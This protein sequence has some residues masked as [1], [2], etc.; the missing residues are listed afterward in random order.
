MSKGLELSVNAIVIIL[1]TVMALVIIGMFVMG[2]ITKQ[3]D[4]TNMN[5]IF[6]DKCAAYKSAGCDWSLTKGSDFPSFLKACKYLYGNEYEA[7]SC[8][9]KFCCGT[10]KSVECDGLCSICDANKLAGIETESCC[11]KFASSCDN[12]G[13]TVCSG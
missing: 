6:A 9:E 3:Q 10:V 2:Q 7:L 12:Y 13:C 11:K 5:K 1:I 8:L 4:D